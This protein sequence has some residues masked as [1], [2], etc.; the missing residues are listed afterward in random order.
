MFVISLKFC[1]KLVRWAPSENP[2]THPQVNFTFKV[3]YLQISGNK[4]T[5]IIKEHILPPTTTLSII[6]YL[7]SSTSNETFKIV[8]LIH[9]CQ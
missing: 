9:L 1:K 2:E 6:V 3:T 5:D 8:V 4:D 7:M